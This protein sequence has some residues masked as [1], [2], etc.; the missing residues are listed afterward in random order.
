MDIDIENIKAL[1]RNIRI[2]Q[3]MLKDVEGKL[4]HFNSEREKLINSI[5]IL[6]IK[7]KKS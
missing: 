7:V 3:R 1:K 4:R 6:R 2:E 5:A